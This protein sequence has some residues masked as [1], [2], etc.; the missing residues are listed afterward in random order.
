MIQVVLAFWPNDLRNE[1]G[2]E[3]ELELLNCG[4]KGE[5]VRH[6]LRMVMQ[7]SHKDQ[8]RWQESSHNNDDQQFSVSPY[9]YIHE[10]IPKHVPNLAANNPKGLRIL[11]LDGGGTKGLLTLE[12]LEALERQ[13]GNLNWKNQF[14]WVGGTSTGSIIALALFSGCVR[15]VE[16]CRKLYIRLKDEVFTGS[17]KKFEQF[18]QDQFK[19]KKMS[20]IP[21]TVKYVFLSSS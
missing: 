15:T 6:V 9:V 19:D 7:S 2:I 14:D 8:R 5:S 1:R 20:D 16:D 10:E 13:F 17:G 11:S 3:Q 12:M 21:Q 18:L 4:K